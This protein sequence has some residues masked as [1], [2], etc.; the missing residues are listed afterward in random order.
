MFLFDSKKEKRFWKYFQKNEEKIYNFEKDQGKIFDELSIELHKIDNNLT[1]EF[2][3]IRNNRRNFVISAD[4]IKS[5]F[6]SVEK[7]HKQTPKLK[8]FNVIKFRPRRKEL[9]NIEIA[10]TKI[11]ASEVKY[12]LL[13][14][15]ENPNKVGILLLF[16]NYKDESRKLFIQV[17]F[18]FLD[19]ALGEFNVI[20]KVGGV[21]FTSFDSK[22]YSK[23]KPLNNLPKDFDNY[24]K[25]A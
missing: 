6:I 11:K 23:S 7:L 18:L 25:N 13:F 9:S 24:F 22:Y 17:G 10:N 8:L 3:S 5:A 16:K 12:I 15:D 20:T 14:K 2:G 19:E 4:G 21:D 1:F